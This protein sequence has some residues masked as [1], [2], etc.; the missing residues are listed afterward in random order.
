MIERL[1]SASEKVLE[2]RHA[3][4]RGDEIAVANCLSLEVAIEPLVRK[5]FDQA[6]VQNSLALEDDC[7]IPSPC[8]YI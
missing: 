6:F 2:L 3:L 5:E 8:A 1:T 7:S 4:L